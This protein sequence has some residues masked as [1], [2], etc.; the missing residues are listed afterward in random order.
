[1]ADDAARFIGG[2]APAPVSWRGMMAT[3]GAWALTGFGMFSVIDKASGDWVGRVGPL[4]PEGW[5]GTEVG[6][7][8]IPAA[9]GRGY[10]GEAAIAS[11]DWA[12]DTLGWTDVIH[13]IDPLNTPS[14]IV[15]RKLG[16]QDLRKGRLPPPFDDK[17][18]DIWGQSATEWRAQRR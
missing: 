11:I 18:I 12:F 17:D 16:S 2:P 3:A 9:Q 5:P 10:A 14:Q 4:Q 1:M 15:A 7:G 8:I 6:W 13:C